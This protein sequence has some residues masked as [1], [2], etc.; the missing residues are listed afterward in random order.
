MK[1]KTMIDSMPLLMRGKHHSPRTGACFMEFAS[2]LA[3]E[4]WSDHPACT[5][6][7]LA[8]LA[9]YVNDCISDRGR[10]R[11]VEVV[12]DVIGLTTK[13]LRADAIIALRAATTALP[14]VA[15]ERQRVMALAV[16]HC[17]AQ[18]ASLANRAV[19]PMTVQSRQAL[20]DAPAAAA[21]ARRH[22]GELHPSARVFRRQTAPA[23]VRYAV[24]GIRQAS[25]PNPD[26]VLRKLLINAIADCRAYCP[27]QTVET[28]RSPSLSA[29]TKLEERVH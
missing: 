10:Q 4:R 29:P 16:W 21:W 24:D 28:D 22:S 26:E 11:L 5:H 14:V 15:E 6:P 18:R 2:Y 23:I 20:A 7:L 19:G 13:D 1:Q 17:E 25:V 9:R 8:T 3:G 12:P 27:T